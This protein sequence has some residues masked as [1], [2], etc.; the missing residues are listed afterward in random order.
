M[1][2]VWQE[3]ERPYIRHSSIIKNL[4][5]S[6]FLTKKLVNGPLH[7]LFLPH[8]GPTPGQIWLKS[9]NTCGVMSTST[10]FYQNPSSDFVVKAYC[11][12][13]R[14]K[15]N[16]FPF[17][18]SYLF[19]PPDLAMEILQWFCILWW[20]LA[21]ITN[22]SIILVFLVIH[23]DEFKLNWKFKIFLKAFGKK[24]QN[25]EL[26]NYVNQSISM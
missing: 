11:I 23:Q 3:A 14:I 8:S 16:L 1:V 7:D 18:N 2:N 10:K 26:T 13:L 12:F 25:F 17:K 21:T 22:L 4:A 15:S 24:F 5:M 20:F 6:S 19:T 9:I